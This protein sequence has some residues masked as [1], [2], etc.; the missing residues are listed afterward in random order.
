MNPAVHN[1]S[2][3]TDDE[4][5]R[6]FVVRRHSLDE[7]LAHLREGDPPRHAL[8]I[9]Q[10]GMGKSLLLRRVAIT[11]AEES[12][13]AGRWLP[14]LMPEDLYQ[15]R[16]I[17]ELWLA[18]L[19]QLA[20]TLGDAGLA[21]QHDGLLAEPDPAR[22]EALALQR[23]LGAARARGRKLLLL[24]ENFDTLLDEQ[25][26]SEES[27]ALRRALQTE[28]DLLLMATAVKSFPQVEEAGEAF[29]GF[30]HRLD[31]PPLDDSEVR[32]LWRELTGVDLAD[33][34][35][36]AVRILTGGNPRLTTVLGRFSRHPDLSRL[37]EDLNLLVD[38]YTPYFQ[39]T[40]EALPVAERKVFV[41]LAD[42]WAPATAA[43]VAE[44][45]RMTSGMVSA[46]L[47]R[48]VR[49]GAVVVVG[50][51]SGK[52][53]YE[54]TERLYN[55]YHLLRRPDGERRVRAL[56]DVLTHLSRR[57]GRVGEVLPRIVRPAL[58]EL[59]PRELR[60]LQPL[61]RK[62]SLDRLSAG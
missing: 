32:T 7:L 57:A 1:V 42:I 26:G 13:L 5:R 55:L 28:H 61:L 56:V 43:Q 23:L 24:A 59:L 50:S 35:A 15:V 14:L 58:G 47:G 33:D 6:R 20:T 12:G 40:M 3:L 27:W 21:A 2:Q 41:T 30:F 44:R 52:N 18:A 4:V 36:A 54:L 19:H 60:E 8:V 25:M 62:G 11:V 45:A 16:F 31:L 9:G 34:R 17:G 37:D 53:R 22:L 39:A 51:Q 46:L 29:Y 38:E 10:R 49:R 48:L